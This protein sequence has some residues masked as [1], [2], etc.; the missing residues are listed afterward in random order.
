MNSSLFSTENKEEAEEEP[1]TANSF[2]VLF[3]L[4][5]ACMPVCV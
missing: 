3:L 5:A 2:V 4:I 1:F